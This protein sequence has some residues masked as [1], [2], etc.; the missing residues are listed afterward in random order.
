MATVRNR[1]DHPTEDSKS[2]IHVQFEQEFPIERVR[3][4]DGD[5]DKPDKDR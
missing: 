3:G 2:L 5:G 4:E 1:T